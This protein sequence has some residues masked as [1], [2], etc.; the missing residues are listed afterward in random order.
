[1]HPLREEQP[2]S[3]ASDRHWGLHIT[4]MWGSYQGRDP[5]FPLTQEPGT[6]K[7]CLYRHQIPSKDLVSIQ[8]SLEMQPVRNKPEHLLYRFR[9]WPQIFFPPKEVL[10][11]T[12]QQQHNASSKEFLLSKKKKS[13]MSY[14]RIFFFFWFKG[15]TLLSSKA[16]E[17]FAIWQK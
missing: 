3:C 10:Q 17:G 7:S 14:F 9:R 5:L 16:V 8:F 15:K 11:C 12:E 6:Y 13:S 4:T 2:L 1:M